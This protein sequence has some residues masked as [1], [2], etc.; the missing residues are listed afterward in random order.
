METSTTKRMSGLQSKIPDIEKTLQTVQFLAK[1]HSVGEDGDEDGDGEPLEAH[2]ELNDTLFAKAHVPKTREVYLWL[3]ANVMLSYG[4]EEAEG[5]L[6]EKLEAARR[7]LAN[8]REDL[9]FLREQIT[10]CCCEILFHCI[11]GFGRGFWCGIGLVG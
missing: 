4:L 10:V 8:C 5:L 9:D 7:S 11:F 1:Q 2:F 6:G 3:G